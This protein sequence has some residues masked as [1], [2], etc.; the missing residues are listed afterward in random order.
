MIDR[1][2]EFTRRLQDRAPSLPPTLRQIAMV[3]DGRR[4]DVL[5]MSAIE[6]ARRI[7]TSDAS[8]IRTAKALGYDGLPALR[9]SIAMSLASGPSGGFR[10]TLEASAADAH[11]AAMQMLEAHT[12][13]MVTIAED[14]TASLEPIARM[15]NECRRIALFGIGPTSHIAGYGAYLLSRH[16]H[17]AFV[18]NETGR[19]LA[20]QLVGLRHGDGLVMFAYGAPYAEAIAVADEGGAQALRMALV[21]DAPGNPL[22]G[23]MEHVAVVPRGEAR[24]MSLHA[25]TMAW[26]E[27]LVVYMSVLNSERT[28]KELERLE[29]LREKILTARI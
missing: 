28:A 7:G 19:G 23:M 27:A 10:Q 11:A 15:L 3:M 20:D 18:I 5:S 12:R 2:D 24:G 6:L 4:A 17:S 29:K 9:R 22:S 25:T 8:I 26:L 14:I 16:G 13:Q 1:P 21:T